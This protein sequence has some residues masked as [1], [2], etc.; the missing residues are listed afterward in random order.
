MERK[1]KFIVD[2][3]I[4]K[5]DP[6]CNFENLVPGT[7][8]YLTAEFAFSDDWTGYKKVVAFF[9]IMGKEYEPQL[10]KNNRSCVIPKAALMRRAFK[11][12]VVGKKGETKKITNK[13][14]IKQNGGVV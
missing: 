3:Q 13:L 14:E 12:Q 9:S 11:I 7:E 5:P 1:L 4:I 10:L 6:K 2:G 8:E